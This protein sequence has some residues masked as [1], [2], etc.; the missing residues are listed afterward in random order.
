DTLMNDFQIHSRILKKSFSTSYLGNYGT[1]YISNLYFDRP[2]P[3]DYSFTNYLSAYFNQPEDMLFY[4][5]RTPYSLATF[6]SGGSKINSEQTLHFIHTQNVSEEFNIGLEYDGFSSNG[7]YTNQNTSDNNISFQT[8][9]DN[10][11]YSIYANLNLNYHKAKENGGLQSSEWFEANN[12]APETQLVNLSSAR[13]ILNTHNAS[14]MQ[15][16]RM[17]KFGYAQDSVW[18][19]LPSR[20][21]FE[22]ILRFQVAKRNF[23]DGGINTDFFPAPQYDFSETSDSAFYR[24][25]SNAFYIVFNERERK[26]ITAGFKAGIVIELDQ[27]GHSIVPDTVFK[28]PSGETA[29]IDHINRY[30]SSNYSN[31]A[32]SGAF[33]NFSGK[34]FNWDI[35][36]RFYIG[37]YKSADMEINGTLTQYIQTGAGTSR[38]VLSGKIENKSPGYFVQKYTSNYFIWENNFNKITETRISGEY[39][40][41]GRNLKAGVYLSQLNE[42]IYF[43]EEA[44]PSQFSGGIVT[45]A[46]SL[47]KNFKTGH[48]GFKVKGVYQFT[49][50]K[51]IIPLPDFAGYQSSYFETA[52]V[53]NVLNMQ[54]GYDVY[55][56]T[57]FDAYA[58]QPATGVFNLQKGDELNHMEKKKIGNYP[59]ID[60]FINLKLK[61]TRIFLKYEHLNA[62]MMPGSMKKQYYATYG[63]PEHPGM[64]KLG[65]SW[66]FYD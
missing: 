42:Y 3:S 25:F 66:G 32:V 29:E 28:A 15:V 23:K 17:G 50:E 54:I 31:V 35:N 18:T 9:Y 58:Y 45:G 53:K 26:K 44:L 5:T 64:F 59:F 47:E 37:G 14:L 33:Y 41:P 6:V 61:R 27:Y 36:G 52:L 13:T 7:Y 63:Y 43:N 30:A 34:K 11:R 12:T 10:K 46:A 21:S 60:V 40:H 8:N 39:I 57:K 1:S 24:T 65:V 20:F 22:H 38:I 48:F 55:Y 56:T 19:F 62:D 51:D 16:Y 2:S 49:S 4:R